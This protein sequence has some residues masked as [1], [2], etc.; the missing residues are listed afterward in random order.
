MKTGALDFLDLPV[1]IKSGY[2]GELSI[3]VRVRCCLC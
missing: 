2:I 3:N 1:E